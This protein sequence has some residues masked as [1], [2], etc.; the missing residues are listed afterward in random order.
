MI[1]RATKLRWRRRLR[2]SKVAAQDFGVHTE[3][4]LEKHLF[5]RLSRLSGVRRF[6]T[7]WLALA[8]LLG[9]S[10]VLQTRGLSGYYQS[11]QPVPGGSYTEGIIGSFTNA[12]PLYASG[13]VDRAVSR[14]L[15]SGLLTYNDQ[16]QLVGDLALSWE[17]DASELVYTVR[18]RQD[19][20]WHDGQPLTA[21]DVIF[22][23]A[24]IQNP[25]AK[26][27]LQTSW[28]G[29][30][31][32]QP[33][34]YTV[35]FRLPNTLSAFPYALTNGIVPQHILKDVPVSQLRS[36]RFNTL[37]PV[38]TGAFKWDA[39]QV[40]GTDIETRQEVIGL[41]ANDS[42]YKGAPKLERFIVRTYRDEAQLLEGFDARDIDAM[43]GLNTMPDTLKSSLNIHEHSVPL[44]GQ[45]MI[46][47]RTGHPLL[48]DTKVRQALV[49]A[50]D[51]K[52]IIAG[53][54]HS[55]VSARSPLLKQ[56]I[57]YT[58]DILQFPTNVDEANALLNAAGWAMG[59]DGI[60]TRGAEF[61]TFTLF[62][63]SNTEYAYVT[64]TLQKQW[65]AVGVDLK[66]ELLEE[67]EFQTMVAAHA[68]DALL[69][70][71]SLGNDPDVFAYWHS[72]QANPTSAS[73]L[74]LSE[75]K[76]TPAD[77]AL[78]AGRTR[79]D[80]GL[81]AAK[82]RPFLET[83]R[84]DAPALAL[85]QPRFLYVTRGPL[86]GFNANYMN[87]AIDRYNAVETWMAR[88]AKQDKP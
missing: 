33:D 7:A 56:H 43:V 9:V 58:R 75:Y 45:V 77:R 10:L 22:T 40:L 3:E 82:Y 39:I 52:S 1:N 67:S 47:F 29:I 68:Y 16:N 85:Y 65:L 36:T 35:V 8:V 28:S 12:S 15:F 13:S 57:G 5:K 34:D 48:Q 20:K 19:V 55:V 41:V 54:D 11:L 32:E 72:S 64:Q 80:P 27:P 53:L 24:T 78:E 17:L 6:I 61:L 79:S 38:G 37:S 84:N 51:T 71:I 25:D 30:R 88:L 2:H 86:A 4:R 74:N 60:R 42:Y 70:G 69:Y 76:S 31:L 26:S 50:S 83:W 18:L 73:R 87:S 46:F 23:Y 44:T 21:K 81:R 66:V 62:A 59:P 49:K 63:Q 14:L